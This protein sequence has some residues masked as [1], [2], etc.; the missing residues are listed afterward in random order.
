MKKLSLIF[1]MLFVLV[2][3]DAWGA[4]YYVAQ[5]AA[6][7]ANGS[8]V[9]NASAIATFNAGTAPYNDLDDDT[10]YLLDTII[11]EVLVPDTGSSGHI[12]TIRGDYT[13]HPC[14][15]AITTGAY[16]IRAASRNYVTI[17]GIAIVSTSTSTNQSG[18][19][20]TGASDHITISNISIDLSGANSVS[21][22]YVT[23]SGALT[24]STLS[25]ISGIGASEKGIY[26]YGAASSG[27]T[28]STISINGGTGVHLTNIDGLV[29][30]GL[31]TANTTT[32]SLY[33][34]T[35]V[36][37][38][39]QLSNITITG[40]PI[41]IKSC[42]FTPGSYLSNATILSP[43]GSGINIESSA[44]LSISDSSV[45]GGN[46]S[47]CLV[48]LTSNN[49]SFSNCVVSDCA[50]VGYWVSGTAY[51]IAFNDCSSLR[52]GGDG[53]GV[54]GTDATHRVH[55]VVY[56]RCLSSGNGT[57][58]TTTDG[59]G[60]TAHYDDYNINY[61]YCTSTNNTCTGFG[62]VGTTSGKIINCTS[63]NNG[64]DWRSTGGLDQIRGGLYLSLTDA[65]S[66]TG[67]SWTIKNYIG[68]HNYP[69]ELHISAHI[70]D[71]IAL[72]NNLYLEYDS[73]KFATI[74][75]GASDITW[76]TY[77][78]TYES[79]SVN[80]DPLF[81]S[82]TDFHL[83][84]GSPCVKGGVFVP[85]VHDQPSPNNVDLGGLEFNSMCIPIGAY[86]RRCA[87]LD[88]L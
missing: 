32:R 45:S 54:M 55:D 15:I 4:T 26:L 42:T 56:R 8:S 49:I 77:H 78:A 81:T 3:G 79:D 9:D 67:V 82:T 5:S 66:I 61:F 43:S 1:L 87:T 84:P 7:D 69:R 38:A 88:G 47:G 68:Y 25:D 76:A 63:A 13:G 51:D 36:T 37:G 41:Y 59:D 27:I 17:T 75:A 65:N 48:S 10:V 2:G 50:G 60:F 35:S 6:G 46:S 72:Q 52:N 44:N 57:K 62:L 83:L 29:I 73:N 58:T 86:G 28:L 53:F 12:V 34:Y 16:S 64:G 11:T 23:S 31:T 33:L 40:T 71:I 20:I 30:N 19:S 21:T 39:V 14:T 22:Y 85:G 18:V 70:K 80:A 74:D 24:N